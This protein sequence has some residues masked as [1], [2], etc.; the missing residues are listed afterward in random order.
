MSLLLL[1]YQA[2][3]KTG[4]GHPGQLR[5]GSNNG[6]AGALGSVQGTRLGPIWVAGL[7]QRRDVT[8]GPEVRDHI[9]S[10]EDGKAVQ[11]KEKTTL[12]VR[13]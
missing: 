11:E 13:C 2:A 8:G 3:S 6:V 7:Q 1:L 4:R 9:S 5:E 10:R 12:M